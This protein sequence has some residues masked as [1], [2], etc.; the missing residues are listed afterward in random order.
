MS[1]DLAEDTVDLCAD[2][3]RIDTSNPGRTERAAAEFVA[4]KLSDAGI[5]GEVFESEPGRATYVARL[6]GD[7]TSP[8]AL[9]VHGHLDVVPAVAADWRRHPFS[10]EL[11][12]GCLWGRGAVDM[13]DMVAMIVAAVRRM[14]ADGVRPRRDLVLAFFADEEAGGRLGARFM[15]EEHP[16]VFEGASAAVGEV[17]GF[18][19]TMGPGLRVYP[20]QIAEKG[21]AWM[22]V[23]AHGRAG[24]GSMPHADSA[25]VKLCEA[26]ARLGRGAFAYHLTPATEAAFAELSRVLGTEVD[27]S[28]PARALEGLGPLRAFLEPVLRNTVS[29]TM[30][31]AGQKVNVIP[32]DAE[33]MVDGRFLPGHEEGFLAEV[34]RLLGPGVTREVVTYGVPV[35]SPWE[36]P[37]VH[38]M[39]R[40]LS[41]A[42]PA[43]RPIPH[44]ISGGTDAKFLSR[45]GMACYGFV[46][47]L[48]PPDLDFASMFHG[49]DER[50]PIDALRFGADVL[51]R[52]L[53]T[54]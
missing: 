22:R 54:Y 44:M 17:G 43:A 14:S 48:L 21:L 36:H 41:D 29:P 32:S 20:I 19:V 26:M 37:L 9:V 34:D 31:T 47:L 38:A 53:T 3:L 8:E 2:L 1:A 4:E 45:L 33:A 27:A 30:L 28:D 16:D 39:S 7:G 35:Q 24:H 50:V 25:V 40:A 23:R 15:V 52:L 49:V 46:P 5:D 11:A 12:E 42:D 13:K 51:Y 10:G 18:S 6:E